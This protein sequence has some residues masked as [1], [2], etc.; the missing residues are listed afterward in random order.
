MYLNFR[1][2]SVLM[3]A[4]N[5]E[6][7][8]DRCVTNVL[9][10]PLPGQLVREILIVD[11]GSRDKTWAVAQQLAAGSP[12]VRLFRNEHNCGKGAALRRA[13]REMTGDLAIF[14]DADLEYDPRDYAALLKPILD[15][16]ADIVF[17]S[18]FANP[19]GE[20]AWFWHAAMNRIL[21][22]VANVVHGTR[23]TD[24]ETCYKA[25]RVD[26][27]RALPLT[28][29]R[30]GIEP[31]ITA[32][33]AR[34]R[35]RISEVP[36]SYRGRRYSEGKKITWKDGIAALWFIVKYRFTK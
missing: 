13:I 25:F 17:G 18:R 7:T 20:S 1:K 8:L 27:L 3:A 12:L 26:A 5:E 9:A 36:I 35:F 19:G 10:T 32:N 30:F 28:A 34:L 15:G 16:R 21:T 29:N 2:L 22:S 31:E 4:F 11:D 14:Q 33:A 23:L 6:A 24:M